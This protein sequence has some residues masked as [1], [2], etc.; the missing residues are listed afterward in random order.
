M[1]FRMFTDAATGRKV[2]VHIDK[3][4]YVIENANGTVRIWTRRAEADIGAFIDVTEDFNTVIS[5][6]NTIV[7]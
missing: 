7:E 4:N 5:R 6:L 1:K 3:V 2:A